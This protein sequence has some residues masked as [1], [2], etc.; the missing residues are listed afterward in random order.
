MRVFG[1][2]LLLVLVCSPA[3]GATYFARVEGT[4]T[5]KFATPF[6]ETM[7][8]NIKIGDRIT[9]TFSTN[10]GD[11]VSELLARSFSALG[12]Y[13]AT[14][15]VSGYKWTSGGDF[16]N[17][18]GPLTEI[19][20]AD[21]LAGYYALMDDSEGGDLHIREYSFEIGEFGYQM[22]VGPGFS[23]TFDKSTLRIAKDGLAFKPLMQL[24]PV[25]EPQTWALMLLGFGFVGITARQGRISSS[26]SSRC[27]SAGG[28][29]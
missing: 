25:P 3:S 16:L 7:S 12:A 29:I 13:Q 23:G 5:E 15:E 6:T 1:L 17:N 2:G 11:S 27:P 18:V 19:D 10:T 20:R 9:A 21:P 26:K 28:K 14:F 8:S 22:Y 24:S 4:I